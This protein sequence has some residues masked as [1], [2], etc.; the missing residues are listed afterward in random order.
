MFIKFAGNYSQM[1]RPAR[2]RRVKYPPLIKEF[3]P[4]GGHTSDDE[5]VNLLMEEYE[6]IRLLDYEHMNQVEAAKQ[7]D[8]SRPTLTR[9][10]DSAR[11]KL[12]LALVQSRKVVVGGGKVAFDDDWFSCAD[13]GAVFQVENPEDQ[14]SCPH[15]ESENVVHLNE[16]LK[17]QP[18]YRHQYHRRQRQEGSSGFCICPQCGKRI[19]HR[20]GTPCRTLVCK[21]CKVTMMRDF[22]DVEPEVLEGGM[23]S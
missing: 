3:I 23:K 6:A 4:V 14:Q 13:C 2:Y 18:R 21:D 10:Y 9:I 19:S 17:S 16:E 15:C 7:M 5:V 22:G 12:A 20:P 1:A 11:K 8:V